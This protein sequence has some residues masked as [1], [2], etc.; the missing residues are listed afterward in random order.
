MSIRRIMSKS[1]VTVAMDDPLSRIKE[2]FDRHG[3]HHLL[4][5]DAGEL[6]GVISDRDLL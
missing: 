5:V 2:T 3:F 6:V 4:V 1:V